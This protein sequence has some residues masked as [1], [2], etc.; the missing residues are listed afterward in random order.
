MSKKRIF[1]NTKFDKCPK[2]EENSIP[3]LEAYHMRRYGICKK[4]LV[5]ITQDVVETLGEEK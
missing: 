1:Y 2:C 3:S 5:K 4:C